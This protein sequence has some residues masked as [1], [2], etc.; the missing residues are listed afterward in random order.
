M[1][2]LIPFKKDIVFKTPV[3]EI[4]SISLEHNLNFNGNTVIGNFV[5]SGNYKINDT[6]I[7]VETFSYELPVEICIDEKYILTNATIDITDFYYELINNN[8]LNVNIEVTIDKLQEKPIIEE[9]NKIAEDLQEVNFERT[10]LEEPE[11]C[12][13]EE[14]LFKYTD[15]SDSYTTYNIYIVREGDTIESIIQKY[16]VEKEILQDYNDLEELKIGDKLIIPSNA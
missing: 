7:N 1:K 14:T 12:V 8:T 11:R 9:L 2:K 3:S 5:V 10:V 13:E 16:N 6:S 15:K 4:T